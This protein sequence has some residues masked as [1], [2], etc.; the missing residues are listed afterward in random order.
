M[1]GTATERKKSQYR[2]LPPCLVVVA[3][4]DDL[5]M[6]QNIDGYECVSVPFA[7]CTKK[8]KND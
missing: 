2:L 3:L 7:F 4:F 5:S 1:V 8:T 6:P